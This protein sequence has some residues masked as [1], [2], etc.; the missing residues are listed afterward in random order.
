MNKLL[1][2]VIPCFNEEE[3][4]TTTFKKLDI[5]LS[6]LIKQNKVNSNSKLLFVDDGSKDSTWNLIKN[7]EEVNS[8]ICGLKLSRNYGHQN[9]L[10]AGMSKAIQYSDMII[11]IDAD[12]QDDETVI[13]DM[14]D[15]YLSGVDI[16]YGVRDDRQTD[17]Q[18]KRNTANIF[19]RLMNKIGIE[20]IPNSADFRLMSKRAVNELLKFKERNLFLRG[21]VPLVGFSTDKVFYSRKK[22]MAGNSKYTLGKMLKLAWNGITSFSIVPIKLILFLGIFIVL[23][24]IIMILYTLIQHLHGHIVAGWSSIIISIW[25]IG[26]IQLICI[27]IIGE[28]IG[29]IFNEVKERPRFIID[30]DDYS[31]RF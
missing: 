19:Y 11:T 18:F 17:T 29:K 28:Y 8:H 22:R 20:L 7:E 26:G 1:T 24:S 5:I 25:L 3:I 10:I 31:N 12:L 9:A 16:V 14:V 21:L 23:F 4:L 6:N 30:I 15:K 2:V 13:Y 27:S